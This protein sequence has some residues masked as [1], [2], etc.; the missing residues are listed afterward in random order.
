MVAEM[1][2]I[3]APKTWVPIHQGDLAA[4]AECRAYQL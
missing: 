2:A 1:E 4:V 3:N